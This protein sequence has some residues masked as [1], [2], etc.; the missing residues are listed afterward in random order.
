MP[1]ALLPSSAAAF[2]PRT[3]PSVM[4]DANVPQWLTMT[5]KRVRRARHPLNNPK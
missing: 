2:A 4:L 1:Q 3:P 5:P